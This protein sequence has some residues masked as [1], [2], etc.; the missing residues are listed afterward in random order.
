MSHVVRWSLVVVGVSVLALG[1]QVWGQQPQSKEPTDRPTIRLT[2]SQ[3]A[4]LERQRH[5]I[6]EAGVIESAKTIELRSSLASET[7]LISIIPDGTVVEK[8]TV[9]AELDD[10]MLKQAL[11]KQQ[12]SV[13]H[14]HRTLQDAEA[15][16]EEARAT[17]EQGIPLAELQVRVAELAKSRYLDE[18]GELD[19]QSQKIE[20]TV[21]QLTLQ[22]EQQSNSKLSTDKQ[23]PDVELNQKVLQATRAELVAAQA[24]KRL[25]EKFVKPH[26]TAAFELDVR[27]AKANLLRLKQSSQ[28]AIRDSDST[29][30][31]AKLALK[32]EQD[33]FEVIQ[34]QIQQTRIL[35]P[36]AGVV[37]HVAPSIRRSGG[38]VLEQGAKLQ[39]QQLLLKMPDLS[40]L[41]ARI[42]VHESQITRV[43]VGQAVS[44]QLDAFPN[45]EFSGRVIEIDRTPQPQSWLTGN[46]G[47]TY[48]VAVEITEP[49]D[50]MKLGMTVAAEFVLP[51]K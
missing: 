48:G 34:G 20:R 24:E 46:N 19:C 27:Q 12:V 5:R 10:S 47:S 3:R 51:T 33:R 30:R 41:Q 35:A 26:Q 25:L 14:A 38:P 7:T 1:F 2:S 4:A 23:S 8:G 50:A 44:L 31:N 45:R 37:V 15:Q 18:G 16:L 22:L 13:M 36:R 32:A 9:L 40:R 49:S 11:A 39:P 17:V 29:V 6:V 28:K 43:K 21:N 42:E